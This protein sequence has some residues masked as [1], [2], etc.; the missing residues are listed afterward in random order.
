MSSLDSVISV[1]VSVTSAAPAAKNFG[2]P[3]VLAYHLIDVGGPLVTSFSDLDEAVTAGHVSGSAAYAEL[4]AVFSQNPRPEKVKLGRRA[5]ANPQVIHFLPT[6][7]VEGQIYKL[8]IN[9]AGGLSYEVVAVA[10]ASPSVTDIAN[11]IKTAA[12]ALSIPGLTTSVDGTSHAFVCAAGAG[13][14]FNYSGLSDWLTVE[15]LSAAASLSAEFLACAAVDNDWYVASCDIKSKAAIA[16]LSAAMQTR[17]QLYVTESPDSACADSGSTT[18]A[19]YVAKAAGYTRTYIQ[20]TRNPGSKG[21]IGLAARQ[22][23][24]N[25]GSSNWAWK[26]ITGV[27]TDNLSTQDI[28]DLKAK[29]CNYY[30]PIATLS[31][32]FDGISAGGQYM[33]TMQGCD[34]IVATIQERIA[35]LFAS[36]EKIAYTD[37]GIAQIG[38]EVRA[39][40]ELASSDDYKILVLET[41][42]V[43]LPKAAN[44]SGADKLARILNN[45]KFGGTLQGAINRASLAGRLA[46]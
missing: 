19:A 37:K 12:D 21:A 5:T 9:V 13:K 27:G 39:V 34:W 38:N 33:D 4:A 14:A 3:F 32:T 17:K 24:Q 44:V 18:D 1:S 15:D 20:Y 35:A 40:L 10:P 42:Y 28:A 6:A 46:V 36:N 29:N 7:I 2:T 43:T 31:R 23:T 22:L 8:T 30:I 11:A 25:P 26:E 45:V 41:V 16:I